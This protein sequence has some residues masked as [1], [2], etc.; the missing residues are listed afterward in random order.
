MNKFDGAFC[1]KFKLLLKINY[2]PYWVSL[3]HSLHQGQLIQHHIGDLSKETTENKNKEWTQEDSLEIVYTLYLVIATVV[4]TNFAG[5][6]KVPFCCLKSRFS[7]WALCLMFKIF[8]HFF[9]QTFTAGIKVF[10]APISK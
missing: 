7:S 6:E 3:H 9:K 8:K 5:L 2:K 10:T 1:K 4:N